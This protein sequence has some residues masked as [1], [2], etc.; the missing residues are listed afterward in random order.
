[1]RVCDNCKKKI[2]TCGMYVKFG[3]PSIVDGNE[4]EFCSDRCGLAYLG[5]EW[6]PK[7]K[8]R[9]AKREEDLKE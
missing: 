1:M 2:D 9:A 4:F 5:R 7:L 6:I 8:E 3:Y